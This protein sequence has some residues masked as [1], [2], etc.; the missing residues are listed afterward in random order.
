ML[1][2][3]HKKLMSITMIMIVFMIVASPVGTKPKETIQLSQRLMA[4]HHG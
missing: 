1:L 3:D 4:L 2:L